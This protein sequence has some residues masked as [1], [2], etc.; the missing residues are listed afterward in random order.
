M[1][2]F[3]QKAFGL[4]TSP[5]MHDAFDLSLEAASDDGVLSQVDATYYTIDGGA[6]TT[7]TGTF[8][9]TDEGTTTVEYWSVDIAGL[10]LDASSFHPA[11]ELLIDPVG[12]GAR[13]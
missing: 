13:R 4:L 6:D 10:E 7:Y 1:D 12:L 3:S 8:Q 11:S 2:E 5:Q 9:I